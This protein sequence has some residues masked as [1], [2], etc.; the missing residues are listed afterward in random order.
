[1]IV[2]VKD[3]HTY[4]T[5][6]HAAT[7]STSLVLDALDKETGAVTVVG[8]AFGRK[9]TGDWLIA[10]GTVYLIVAVKPE[11]DRTILTVASPLEAFSRPLEIPEGKLPQTCGRCI[12]TTLHTGWIDC[13]DPAY[14][15]GYLVVSNSDTTDFIRPEVDSNGIWRLTDYCRLLRYTYN[16]TVRFQDS[17]GKLLCHIQREAEARHQVAFEDGH[18]QLISVDYSR[19]ATAKITVLQELPDSG[20]P[21]KVSRSVW[22]L[23]EDGTISTQ[24]PAR[25]AEGVWDMLRLR[26]TDDQEARVR[27]AFAKNRSSHK[28]EFWSDRD[29]AVGDRCGFFVYGE[30]LESYISCKKVG[31]EDRRF[32]YRSGELAVTATEKLRGVTN[33]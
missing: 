23:A 4:R 26:A 16:I 12:A 6:G 2:Y 24:V 33:S 9:N 31:S 21:P 29:L 8:T 17:M 11:A 20:D 30:V 13:A 19:K 25:R 1:M 28:L 7:I 32:L 3:Q 27:Q 5:V 15:M 22:Y 14:Q 18:S 10:D